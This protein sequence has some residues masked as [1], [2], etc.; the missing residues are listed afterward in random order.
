MALLVALMVSILFESIGRNSEYDS[1]LKPP[2]NIEPETGKALVRDTIEFNF[3]PGRLNGEPMDSM[4]ISLF[5]MALKNDFV[6][7]RNSQAIADLKKIVK[8]NPG[9]SIQFM[10]M[11][12]DFEVLQYKIEQTERLYDEVNSLRSAFN[13]TIGIIVTVLVA[14]LGAMI[15]I[16]FNNQDK[17]K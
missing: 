13:W 2:P 9:D 3:E 8:E 6:S 12:K 14:V 1:Y 15:T 7:R 16:I 10:L 4:T 5:K 11:R 17:K